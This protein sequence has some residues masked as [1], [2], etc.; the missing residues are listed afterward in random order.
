MRQ[1]KPITSLPNP[2][3]VPIFLALFVFIIMLLPFVINWDEGLELPWVTKQREATERKQREAAEFAEALKPESGGSA[4]DLNMPQAAGN[5]AAIAPAYAPTAG[6]VPGSL[7]ASVTQPPV[8]I[9]QQLMFASQQG[10]GGATAAAPAAN[11]AG[12]GGFG[13]SSYQPAGA[14]TNYGAPYQGEPQA[15]PPRRRV[16]V[17]R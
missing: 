9:D 16:W 13:D 4:A 11:G 8:S 3:V 12:A 1:S 5:G 17:A 7:P 14:S 15:M 2:T 10:F 6:L